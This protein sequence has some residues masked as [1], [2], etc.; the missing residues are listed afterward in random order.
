MGH[1]IFAEQHF[2][3]IAEYNKY[4]SELIKEVESSPEALDVVQ[5]SRLL[6]DDTFEKG[7]AIDLAY[8]G[9]MRNHIKDYY[10]ATKSKVDL[11]KEY[12]DNIFEQHAADF[13]KGS[14]KSRTY[15]EAG[16]KVTQFDPNFARD[17]NRFISRQVRYVNSRPAYEALNNL[18][19]GGA[20]DGLNRFTQKAFKQILVDGARPEIVPYSVVNAVMGQLSVAALGYNLSPI[21]KQ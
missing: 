11:T 20:L 10:M 17:M 3:N 18:Y 6:I 14:Q 21:V 7:R 4:K 9:S 1:D 2:D 16:G 13:D 8:D 19:K 5:F 12:K 15:R